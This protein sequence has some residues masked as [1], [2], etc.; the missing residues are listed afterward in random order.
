MSLPSAS[1]VTPSLSPS[2]S[3]DFPSPSQ[4]GSGNI[5][6]SA[7]LYLYT[8][9]AT[10]V[11]LLSVSAAIVL[12]S[13][14]LRRRHAAAIAAAI[15]NGTYAPP[16]RAPRIDPSQKPPMY[17]AHLIVRQ[18]DDH[19]DWDVMKPGP[20]S[21]SYILRASR[22]ILPPASSVN[23]P[24]ERD[25]STFHV[26]RSRFFPS[27]ELPVTEVEHPTPQPLPDASAGPL[28]VS[29]LLAMPLHYDDYIEGGGLPHIE[30]GVLEVRVTTAEHE[31]AG[32]FSEDSESRVQST[33][34]H[35]ILH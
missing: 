16:T 24:H 6:S 33:G 26:I 9:L 15:R 22:R 12:R 8:F 21:L 4:T 28:R 2:P 7:S 27:S 13:L 5:T 10:L 1:F 30:I 31:K 11:L 18:H 35:G 32:S 29:M 19:L 23:Q 25:Q 20:L 17:E 14:V 3:S 34:V